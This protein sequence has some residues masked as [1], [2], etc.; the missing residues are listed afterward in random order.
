MREMKK[1]D[2]IKEYGHRY[3]PS[4]EDLDLGLDLG[5]R[6]RKTEEEALIEKLRNLSRNRGDG[7]VKVIEEIGAPAESFHYKDLEAVQRRTE[8]E[9]RKEYREVVR[10]IGQLVLD[11][12]TKGEAQS[13]QLKD[14]FQAAKGKMAEIDEFLSTR[15]PFTVK[16]KP[17]KD[18]FTVPD[19]V[20]AQ[21]ATVY[22]VKDDGKETPQMAETTITKRDF[23]RSFH[24]S[25]PNYSVSYKTGLD[26][27]KKQYDETEGMISVDSSDDNRPPEGAFARG[28][29][30]FAFN[31]KA[32]AEKHIGKLL[33]AREAELE[34]QLKAVR[35]QRKGLNS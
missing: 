7:V 24:S 10:T 9:D 19:I 5:G 31:S 4:L 13:K 25:Q 18:A 26:A 3:V 28:F 15:K 22:V 21:G 16:A 6:R 32:A 30:S 1:E 27:G 34:A 20:A 17:M 23:Y 33:D 29:H 11:A 35:A 14:A 12:E 2:A 8:T